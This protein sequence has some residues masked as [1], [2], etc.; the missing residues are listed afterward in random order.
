MRRTFLHLIITII[1][2]PAPWQLHIIHVLYCIAGYKFV[3][4]VSCLLAVDQ[5]KKQPSQ[6]LLSR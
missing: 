6:Q 2:R 4:D 3:Y 1:C 5:W